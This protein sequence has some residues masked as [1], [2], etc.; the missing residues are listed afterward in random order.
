MIAKRPA[1][2]R[3][4][5]EQMVGVEDLVDLWLA[6]RLSGRKPR[7]KAP[8]AQR[9]VAC[10]RRPANEASKLVEMPGNALYPQIIDRIGRGGWA[11]KPVSGREL[12]AKMLKVL[13]AGGARQDV[14]QSARGRVCGRRLRARGRANAP[15]PTTSCAVNGKMVR[16]MTSS[17]TVPIN[18]MSMVADLRRGTGQVSVVGMLAGL[19]SLAGQRRLG[20]LP[21][22]GHEIHPGRQLCKRGLHF[23]F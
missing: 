22:N 7:P 18:R 3:V 10:L 11:V 6:L 21:T 1:Q 2:Q 15:A 20:E 4:V 5:A 8:Q 17:S 14:E 19:A 16:D 12:R 13:V 9:P 23:E